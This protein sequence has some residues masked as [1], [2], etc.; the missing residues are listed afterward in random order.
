MTGIRYTAEELIGRRY[1]RLEILK[2]WCANSRRF[3]LCRC[4]CGM[5]KTILFGNMNR[6]HTT[7]CGCAQDEAKRKRV[8]HGGSRKGLWE[9]LY[10]VWSGMLTRCQNKHRDDY[11]DYGLRGILVCEEWAKDYIA[12]RTWAMKNNYACGLQIDRKNND[13]GYFP[14][15]CRFV[16]PKVNNRNRRNTFRMT[17]NGITLSIGEWSERTRI[18]RGT[19]R[20]RVRRYGWSVEKALTTPVSVR[21]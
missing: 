8:K 2:T 13:G 11:K 12:F 1:G 15:N 17:L 5:T 6:L 14:E 10:R 9:P 19:I 16:E 21:C 3:C 20:E 18:A 7:S 4:D